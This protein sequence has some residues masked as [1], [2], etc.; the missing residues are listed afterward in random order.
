[1]PTILDY[2]SEETV[3]VKLK[4]PD[5][6]L[7][8]EPTPPTNGNFTYTNDFDNSKLSAYWTMIRTPQS[9]WWNISDDGQLQIESRSHTISGTGNTSF[10]C[11]VQKNAYVTVFTK[12]TFD[13]EA[14]GNVAGL[15]AFQGEH[16]YYLV[17]V[18]ANE[19][20][21]K[22]MYLEKSEGEEKEIIAS[23]VI[24]ENPD[25]EYYLKI[26]ARGAEYD[27][28]YGFSEDKWQPLYEGADGTIL[29]TTKAGGFVGTV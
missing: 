7:G 27:F 2:E 18:T 22:E 23:E 13:P 4:R 10:I 6:P 3:P 8:E 19:E 1:W 26:Q 5:L 28:S 20:G 9:Q 15:V 14:E 17:G 29:S 21:E 25:N 11:M 24:E 12:M 16:Y